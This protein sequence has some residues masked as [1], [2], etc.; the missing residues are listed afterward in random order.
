MLYL[1]ILFIFILQQHAFFINLLMNQTQICCW[2][3]WNTSICFKCTFIIL[4]LQKTVFFFMKP[5]NLNL[6]LVLWQ[7]LICQLDSKCNLI[8]TVF[9]IL[10]ISF[11]YLIQFTNRHYNVQIPHDDFINKIYISM[12]TACFK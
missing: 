5:S 10:H 2:S 7:L 12:L 1:N 3:F 6:T 8:T 9:I 11:N 4:I